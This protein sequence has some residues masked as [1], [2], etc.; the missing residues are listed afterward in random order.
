MEYRWNEH[1]SVRTEV[2]TLAVEEA[3]GWLGWRVSAPNQAREVLPLEHAIVASREAYLV[4]RGLGRVK[5][6]SLSRSPLSVQR[7]RRAT[8]LTRLLSIGLCILTLLAFSARQ[9]LA[10]SKATVAGWDAG[11]PKR[12]PNRPP[13]EALPGAFQGIHLSEVSIGQQL[14]RRVTPLSEVQLHLFALLDASPKLSDHL[15][16]D[17]SK[18]T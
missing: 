18:P 2:D 15:G 11:K 12:T 4:E 3:R 14:H 5:G 8:G 1:W 16:A 9:R 6:K 10:D 7:D 13:A 17:F